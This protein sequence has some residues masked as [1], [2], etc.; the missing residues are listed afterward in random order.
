M[1]RP[2]APLGALGNRKAFQWRGP[3]LVR[4]RVGP[5]NCGRQARPIKIQFTPDACPADSPSSPLHREP[6]LDLVRRSSFLSLPFPACQSRGLCGC[7]CVCFSFRFSASAASASSHDGVRSPVSRVASI[8]PETTR[9]ELGATD[10][11]DTGAPR[12]TTIAGLTSTA[13]ITTVFE[14]V[15]KYN[16][17]LNIFERLWAV[18]ATPEPVGPRPSQEQ[19]P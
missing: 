14:E 16:V 15:S 17:H 13:S 7:F 19:P 10:Q 4:L 3:I 18:R 9:R 1:S 6:A 11:T 2:I 12:N 8:P 5:W